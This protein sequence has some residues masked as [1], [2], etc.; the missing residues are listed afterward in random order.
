MKMNRYEN[1]LID[2]AVMSVK[3]NHPEPLVIET[4][5]LLITVSLLTGERTLAHE[6]RG[7][8]YGSMSQRDRAAV[9][10]RAMRKAGGQSG[11]APRAGA[12]PRHGD[13]DRGGHG[14]SPRKEL[15]YRVRAGAI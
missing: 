9:I 8:P 15:A 4:R 1:V 2:G 3:K 13:A 12:H 5:R 6:Y 7:I 11:R 10:E 14:A